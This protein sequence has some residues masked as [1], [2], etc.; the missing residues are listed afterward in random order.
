MLR[1]LLHNTSHIQFM[2]TV[3]NAELHEG[4]WI[5]IDLQSKTVINIDIT[6]LLL[7]IRNKANY[8]YFHILHNEI[9]TRISKKEIQVVT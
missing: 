2:V 3:H 6:I 8:V 1:F 5:V 4:L 7:T 9:T